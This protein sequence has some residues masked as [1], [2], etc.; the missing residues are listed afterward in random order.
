MSTIHPTAVI[1]PGA[2]LGVDV[3]VGPYCV[4]GPHVRVGD[5]T[6]LVSHVV[7]DGHLTLGRGCRVFPFASLGAITQDLKYRG[8]APRAEIGDDTT[9]RECV[10][11]NTATADGDVT[12]VGSRCLLMAYSHVAHDCVVGDEVILANSV[13]LAG[14]V[15]IEDRASLGGMSGVHQFGR[16]GTLAYIGALAKVT[17]DVMPY[18]IVDGHP[19]ETRSINLVGLQRRGHSA[20]A[21]A[22]LRTAH[23]IL[24]RE[25]LNV[26]QALER[27]RAELSGPE[28]DRL[29]AFIERSE[30]GIIR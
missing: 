24:C 6:H 25:G 8:G 20:E 23:R 2:E 21:C 1:A 29:T 5:G 11:I 10:T 9:I 17:Q 16:V 28:I 7:L 22:D 12:R 15:T 4:I 26:R 30:R 13:A 14:H 3:E 18:M 19:A 27:I